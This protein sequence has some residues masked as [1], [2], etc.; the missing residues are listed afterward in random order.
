MRFVDIFYMNLFALWFTLFESSCFYDYYL[1]KKAEREQIKNSEIDKAKNLY[2][3][4]VVWV[5]KMPKARGTKSKS[6]VDAFYEI[7]K[8]AKQKDVDF[9]EYL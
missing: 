4:E 1:E 3:K 9:K 8:K 7:E 6:R 5:R 2:R